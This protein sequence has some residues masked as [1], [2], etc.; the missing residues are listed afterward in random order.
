MLRIDQVCELETVHLNF[1]DCV[2]VG[3]LRARIYISDS[4]ILL[5]I[6]DLSVEELVE[7]LEACD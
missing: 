6:L 3:F 5:L 7:I 2:F 4:D 1:F